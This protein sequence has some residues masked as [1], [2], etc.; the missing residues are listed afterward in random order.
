MNP[1][2]LLRAEG[3]AVFAGSTAAYFALDGSPWLFLL[4][5][6]APDLSMAGYLAGPRVG[7]RLYNLGHTYVVPLGIAGFGLWLSV[8]VAVLV[9]LV[10]T[11]HIGFDRL[12]GYGLKYPTSF[13]DTHLGR[14][15]AREPPTEPVPDAET[16]D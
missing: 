8:P 15:A 5:L 16:A 10:W 11:A 14:L 12:V 13:G 6:F 2:L 9:A 7:S 4:L 1:R 3:L